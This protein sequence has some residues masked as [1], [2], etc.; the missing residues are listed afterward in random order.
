MADEKWM[1]YAPGVEVMVAGNLLSLVNHSGYV[2]EID[3]AGFIKSYYQV[4]TGGLMG[5]NVS[6][7]S[8]GYLAEITYSIAWQPF[9]PFKI[10]PMSLDSD[11]LAFPNID[12]VCGGYPYG[13]NEMVFRRFVWSVDEAAQFASTIDEAETVES[14]HILIDTGST[15]SNVQKLTIRGGEMFSIYNTAVTT[16]TGIGIVDIWIEFTVKRT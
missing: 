12:L 13:A 14:T 16:A 9:Q 1:A 8:G 6:R 11:N 3:R 2:V 4:V 15:D 10:M 5:G 7:F